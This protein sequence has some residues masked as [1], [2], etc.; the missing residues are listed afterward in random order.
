MPRP[1]GDI[2]ILD[3]MGPAAEAFAHF[4]HWLMNHLRGGGFYNPLSATDLAIPAFREELRDRAERRRVASTDFRRS[5]YERGQYVVPHSVTDFTGRVRESSPNWYRGNPA[6]THRLVPWLNR[7]L[8]ALMPSAIHQVPHVLQQ[9][10]DLIERYPIQGVDFRMAMDLYLGANCAHFQHEFLNFARSVYDMVGYDR[11]AQY[12]PPPPLELQTPPAAPPAPVRP[13]LH[14]PQQQQNQTV[15]TLDVSSSSEEETAAPS[16]SAQGRQEEVTPST[17]NVTTSKPP[18]KIKIKPYYSLAEIR[19][20]DEEDE[21]DHGIEFLQQVKKK[22]SDTAPEVIDIPSSPEHEGS[23]SRSDWEPFRGRLTPLLRQCEEEDSDVRRHTS[24]SPPPSASTSLEAP[25]MSKGNPPKDPGPSFHKPK[26]SN[27]GKGKGKKSIKP[28]ASMTQMKNS[29]SSS[30]I[31]SNSS[32]STISSNGSSNVSSGSSS[33]SEPSAAS[34]SNETGLKTAKSGQNYSKHAS[35]SSC[36]DDSQQPIKKRPAKH[37]KKSDPS[38]HRKEP[39]GKGKGKGKKST[40][41]KPTSET[42]TSQPA[43]SSCSSSDS[44]ASSTTLKKNKPGDVQLFNSGRNPQRPVSSLHDSSLPVKKRRRLLNEK[45][46]GFYF[47]S[48]ASLTKDKKGK[49][50]KKR[51]RDRDCDDNSRITKDELIGSIKK[52]KKKRKKSKTAA[53]VKLKLNDSDSSDEE[54]RVTGPP[55]SK[56]SKFLSQVFD[57]ESSSDEDTAKRPLVKSEVALPPVEN[58]VNRKFEGGRLPLWRPYSKALADAAAETKRVVSMLNNVGPS[59]SNVVPSA[60]AAAAGEFDRE[61]L[62]LKTNRRVMVMA[63]EKSAAAAI[64]E[65]ED[66]R[67]LAKRKKVKKRHKSREQD[68]NEEDLRITLN[69]KRALITSDL[70]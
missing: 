6:Q 43:N 24:P 10:L 54:E 44:G 70:D 58:R 35:Q 33:E 26:S 22:K 17:S 11:V 47:E 21:S 39:S 62:P 25:G 53:S 45:D 32:S 34:T 30:S 41:N 42:S 13:G 29:S 4:D 7:E 18:D 5:I 19:L 51:Q 37:S 67:P 46:V 12:G 8:N 56:R 31:S 60:A 28:A 55:Q 2:E 38:L 3:H 36:H 68:N 40:A 1:T 49:K 14:A 23:A 63:E 20:S 66:D 69:R 61:D 65:D 15:E 50:S 59:A 57:S 64:S 48:P 9:V 27:K 52:K 16:T